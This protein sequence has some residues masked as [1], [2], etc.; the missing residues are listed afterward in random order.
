MEQVH[1]KLVGLLK[2]RNSVLDDIRRREGLLA[3]A[4]SRLAALEAECRKKGIEPDQLDLAIEKLAERYIK[5]VDKLEEQI[6]EAETVLASFIHPG[7]TV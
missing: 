4:E 5:I 6:V 1:Q 3:G 2:R 7:D